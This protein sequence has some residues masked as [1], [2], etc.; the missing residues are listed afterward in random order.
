MNAMDRSIKYDE[1]GLRGEEAV[2]CIYR[3]TGVWY[4]S[5][6]ESVDWFVLMFLFLR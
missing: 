6:E 3:K 5:T 4:L 2:P 1:G